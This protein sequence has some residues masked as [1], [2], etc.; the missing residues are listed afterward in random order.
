MRK[1]LLFVGLMTVLAA[2]ALAQSGAKG[3][4]VPGDI[5]GNFRGQSR[6][7]NLLGALSPEQQAMWMR[8]SHVGAA[9]AEQDNGRRQQSKKLAGMTESQRH[10]VINKLQTDFDKLPDREKDRIHQQLAGR[11][12]QQNSGVR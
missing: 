8:Q 9:A 6:G 2:P 1:S 3:P 4:P 12:T 5:N 11:M 7:S 10:Q